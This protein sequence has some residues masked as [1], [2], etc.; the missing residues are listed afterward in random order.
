MSKLECLSCT[1]KQKTKCLKIVFWRWCNDVFKYLHLDGIVKFTIITVAEYMKFAILT[2]DL[3][4]KC[5]DESY[6]VCEKRK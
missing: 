4:F 5:N 1:E 3:V 6:D 2:Y